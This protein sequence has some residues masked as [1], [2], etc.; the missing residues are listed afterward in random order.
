MLKYVKGLKPGRPV[1][2]FAL[3]ARL[4]LIQGITT[5]PAVLTESLN[6]QKGGTP[7]L[8]SEAD[9]GMDANSVQSPFDAGTPFLK[10]LQADEKAD[11][12]DHLVNATLDA[13]QELA[14]SLAG[15]PGRKNVVWLSGAFPSI[16]L[17]DPNL[18]INPSSVARN[19]EDEVRKTDTLL[20][21]AQVAIYPIGVK[22][23]ATNSRAIDGPIKAW[24][25]NEMEEIAS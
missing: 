25:E 23:L 15:V 18:V 4:R 8:W 1:A 6:K 19:Y 10:Q 22:G 13:F 16:V 9:L 17:A 21:A 11:Q 20:A 2:I 12:T 7:L 24:R 5:D 14:R 3:G